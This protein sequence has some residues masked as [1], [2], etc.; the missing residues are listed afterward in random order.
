MLDGLR[1][2]LN[3]RLETLL[4]D[5]SQSAEAPPQDVDVDALRMCGNNLLAAG[6]MAQAEECFR[7]ALQLKPDDTP[8]LVCLGYVLKEQGRL[9]EARVALRKA[10]NTSHA[11]ADVHET[12]YL[13]GQI[14]EQQG[15]LEDAV[16]QYGAALELRPEFS[17]AC[18]D[19]CRIYQQQGNTD[20]VRAT[21]QQCVALR[22]ELVDYRLW[23]TDVC[24]Y[25]VDYP[26][27]VEHLRAALRLGATTA[28]NYMTLG[29]ALCR[30][31]DITEGEQMLARGEAMD[32]A[33]AYITQF[34]VGYYHLTAGDHERGLQHMERCIALR[35][36]FLPPHSSVLMTLSHAR[37]RDTGDYERAA[38]RYAEV[39]RSQV[40]RPLSAD[41]PQA[42]RAEHRALRIGWVSGDLHKHPV[43]YFLLDV[44]RD[45]DR[46]GVTLVAY[47]NNP[48][49][50][51]ITESLKAL[52]DEWHSI[53]HLSD[54]AAAELVRS[55]EIDVLVDLGG[56]TG[57]NRLA[58]FGRRPAPVQVS[59]L[60][61]WASTGLKEIDYILADPVSVPA[62][63]T[64]WFAE[65]VYRLP[66]TR[67]CL[68]LPQTSRPTPV[69]EPPMLNNGY[70]TFGSFQQVSKMTPAVL[71]VWAR[72][73]GAVPNSRLRLQTKTLGKPSIRAKLSGELSQAGIDLAR[74]EL[75][76]AADL[77]LYLEAHGKVD[78]LLD[79]FPYPGGTTTAFALWMG[80][81][82]ITLAGDTML[83]RQGE[84]MLG[85]VGLGDW[86]AAT[87][88][89]YVDLARSKSADAAGLAELR[90]SLR[91][92]AEASPLFDARRFAQ[93]LKAA[94]FAMSKRA[95][96]Q[97]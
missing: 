26:G 30:I 95:G 63:S 52:F 21:L 39:I 38:L 87:E 77:D 82:T 61:Y 56:H 71:A 47:A 76:D 10:I 54:D 70:V 6:D 93:D 90:R 7:Q 81:P 11:Q 60:G 97:G 31:G 80:V 43:A 59:W 23:L 89:A 78:I 44:L 15:D 49:S 12:Y 84:S 79:T 25:E 75:L 45:F 92:T 33:Q 94:L 50:D 72:V 51:E 8:A 37:R 53:R 42:H 36:D 88:A 35:P 16:R 17:R 22:P 1:R 62:G 73:L 34:E 48:V 5:L 29:A 3:R 58:V 68:A 32:P 91:A 4:G 14:S 96:A 24:A 27:V 40:T 74:V 55:H 46:Q 65:Q 86:V 41:A 66:H 18:K 69:S 64:E 28:Q 67:L 9:A 85:C 19:L 83:A 13:L 2:R 57:E 20:A